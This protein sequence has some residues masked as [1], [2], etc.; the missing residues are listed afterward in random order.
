VTAYLTSRHVG[1]RAF[2]QNYAVIGSIM[3]LSAGVGPLIAGFIYDS[4]GSY[5]LMFYGGI[6]AALLA[7]LCIATMG[8]FP[9]WE[10]A[11]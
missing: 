6:P 5:T 11:E 7:G 3:A 1:P 8:P 9:V 4:T 2:A 10:T